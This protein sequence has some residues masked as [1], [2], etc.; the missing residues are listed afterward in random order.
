[1]SEPSGS[2]SGIGKQS[3][4]HRVETLGG[5]FRFVNLKHGLKVFASVPI[6]A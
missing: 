5:S 2:S 6:A 1:L 4:R 3:M